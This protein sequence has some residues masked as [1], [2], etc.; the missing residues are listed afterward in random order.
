CSSLDSP[1]TCSARSTSHSIRTRASGSASPRTS[2]SS[3]AIR[4]N[5]ALLSMP[6]PLRASDPARSI[7]LPAPARL[8]S[9]DSFQEA[10]LYRRQGFMTTAILEG[11]HTRELAATRL[12]EGSAA[13]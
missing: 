10:G 11:L 1:L 4:F 5:T 6:S 3:R 8:D 9:L 7:P 2:D 12:F 13:R